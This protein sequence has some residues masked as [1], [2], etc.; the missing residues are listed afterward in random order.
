MHIVIPMSGIGKRFIEAGYKDP[1]PLI[2]VDGKP[3]IHHVIDLF[4]GE[5]NF[6]F[7][8]NDEHL[9]TTRMREVL[10]E[11]VPNA[12]IHEVSIHNRKGPVDA[13]LQI[14]D[15][16]PDNEEVIISYCDY[17]TVW[18]YPGFLEEMRKTHS[19]GGIAAY[20]GFH[21]H[22]LGSDN[23]A[24]MRHF[25]QWVTAIQEKKPYTDNKMNEYASNGTYYF[26]TGELMKRFCR[27]VVDQ[28]LSVNGEFYVSLA[29]DCMCQARLNV[30][31]FEIEKMLQWGTPKDLEEYKQW[32][33]VFR[34]QREA[35][36]RFGKPL[37]VTTILPM[38]GAG[39]RFHMV[40]YTDPKPLLTVNGSP[41]FIEA[42]NC[43][44]PTTDIVFVCQQAHL[45]AYPIQ[46]KV[47]CATNTIGWNNANVIGIPKVTEGQACTCEIAINE[48]NIPLDKPILISACDNGAL[49]DTAKH[50]ALVDDPTVDVIVWAFTNSATGKLYPHMYAWLDVDAEGR[51]HE[52]SIKKPFQDKP[53][54]H[55]I[56][57]TMFFRTGAMFMEG[58]ADCYATNNRTNG[59]FYVDNVLQPLIAKGY[60]VR[61]FEVDHYLCWGT[62]NDYKTYQYWDS[63]WHALQGTQSD[64]TP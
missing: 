31:V 42:V 6:H 26:R 8:C 62:P 46:E 25:N 30:R 48:S 40:G 61:V 27:Q 57:G 63:H 5:T 38:A 23:Y 44:P 29:M 58:L 55:A 9:A 3:M 34:R 59:E 39:S 35:P 53:N 21:P 45:D 10:L 49:Y 18:D 22:M 11:K 12:H 4:P 24:F 13:V 15:H 56:I 54:T 32:A 17:G 47:K 36:M 37:D 7:I 52:V 16:L 43:L 60:N 50:A 2:E 14:A 64:T 19:D 33:E 51:I 28:N 1:K 41:M 20:I